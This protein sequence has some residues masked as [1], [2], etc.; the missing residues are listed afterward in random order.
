[1]TVSKFFSFFGS[2][3]L[4]LSHWITEGLAEGKLVGAYKADIK[5]ILD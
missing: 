3:G 2:R 4:R 1:M 5:S